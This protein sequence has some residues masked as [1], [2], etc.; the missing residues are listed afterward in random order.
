MQNQIGQV[1]KNE[2]EA[3]QILDWNFKNLQDSRRDLSDNTD[4]ESGFR[5]AISSST[6]Y[7]ETTFYDVFLNKEGQL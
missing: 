5:D 2:F 6:E 3:R 4:L 1:I 7:P